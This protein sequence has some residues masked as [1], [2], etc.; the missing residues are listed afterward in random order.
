[1]KTIQSFQDLTVWQKSITLVE[2]IYELSAKLPA[3]EK[4]GLTSQL[5]KTAVSIP[6]NIA[7]GYSRN[8]RREFS[9]FTGISRGSAAE[10]ETQLIIVKK[11]Y[12]LDINPELELLTEIRKMLT[13]LSQKLRS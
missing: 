8:N 9:Q 2:N 5:Q 7:E 12:G 10:L 6:S 11:V 4:F 1:M 3:S 13:S